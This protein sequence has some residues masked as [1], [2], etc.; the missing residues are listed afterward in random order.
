M[1]AMDCNAQNKINTYVSIL[2]QI[3]NLNTLIKKKRRDR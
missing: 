1:I 3:N 2:I